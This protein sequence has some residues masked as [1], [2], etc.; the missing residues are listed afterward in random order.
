MKKIALIISIILISATAGFSQLATAALQ[1][2]GN[3]TL[4]NMKRSADTLNQYTRLQA[5]AAL[6]TAGNATLVN[7]KKAPT[8]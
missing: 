3:A 4:V 7:I 2:A 6:Q 8:R 1:T 5:T